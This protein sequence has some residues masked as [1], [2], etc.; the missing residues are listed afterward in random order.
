M[1]ELLE[2]LNRSIIF[3]Y[4]LL[5]NKTF[6]SNGWSF[7]DYHQGEKNKLPGGLEIEDIHN[8]HGPEARKGKFVNCFRIN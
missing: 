4:I 7:F 5:F 6:L 1:N 2:L 8:G 3:F